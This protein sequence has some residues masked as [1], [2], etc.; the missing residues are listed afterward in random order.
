MGQRVKEQAA[1]PHRVAAFAKDLTNCW[2]KSWTFRHVWWSTEIDEDTVG[3]N[4]G[5]DDVGYVTDYNGHLGKCLISGFGMQ[6]T[7]QE[8]GKMFKE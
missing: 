6:E 3:V 2:C 1:L 7:R 8:L 4:E 5:K